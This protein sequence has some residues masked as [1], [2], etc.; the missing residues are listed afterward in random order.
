MSSR[1]AVDRHGRTVVA[2]TTPSPALEVGDWL[3]VVDRV[4]LGWLARPGRAPTARERATARP[5][6]RSPNA[7]KPIEV[8]D[9]DLLDEQAALDACIRE[10]Q[11]EPVDLIGRVPG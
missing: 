5:P 8:P 6:Y 4:E 3:L 2:I 11:R 1:L 7:V 10:Q 9:E